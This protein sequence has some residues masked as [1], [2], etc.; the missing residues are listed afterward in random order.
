MGF[1][2][3]ELFDSERHQQPLSS[4]LMYGC[5][6]CEFTCGSAMGLRNHMG[7]HWKRMALDG[8][9]PVKKPIALRFDGKVS[10][11]MLI[12]PAGD[13]RVYLHVNGKPL[14]TV[15]SE[16]KDMGYAWEAAAA[17]RGREREARRLAKERERMREAEAEEAAAGPEAEPKTEARRGSQRRRSYSAKEK[18]KI[19]QY[20]EEVKAD[21]RISAKVATFESNIRSRGAKVSA[22]YY[23]T[24]SHCCQPIVTDPAHPSRPPH[25]MQWC[26]VNNEWNKPA[27]KRQIEAAAAQEHA[28]TLLRI[29]TNSRKVGKYVRPE[30][31]LY[32]KFKARRARGRKCSAKWF[33]HN[34][35][36]LMKTEFKDSLG[37][38]SFKGSIGWLRRFLRRFTLV[39]RKKTKP[40]AR[41]QPGRRLS[42]SSRSIL[43]LT[44]AA[45]A[46]TRGALHA[47][48][49]SPQRAVYTPPLRRRM[50]LRLRSHSALRLRSLSA[51]R[52]TNCAVASL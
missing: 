3:V 14:E 29:D 50:M 17:A 47:P 32:A 13:V 35:K 51:L 43:L 33:V 6:L 24:P 40:T 45:C 23:R 21:T 1:A 25:P 12:N 26:N 7:W 31:A 22:S 41:M 30:R 48:P 52:V 42:Q 5:E 34:M 49:R 10:A 37:A 16:G 18:V 46:T 19:L 9:V 27:K 4:T 44:A 28:S 39:S 15:L 8:D 2:G 36:W 20:L 11:P 38:A